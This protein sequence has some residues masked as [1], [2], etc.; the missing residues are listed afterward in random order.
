MVYIIRLCCNYCGKLGEKS[1][2]YLLGISGFAL[3]FLSD[4][5]D[6]KWARRELKF[7]FPLGA[8]LL[9][10]GTVLD[11]RFGNAV[12][13]GGLRWM[14]FVLAALL[15]ALEVYT[16]FFA[17]PVDA[18]Y[19]RPGE[20]RPACTTGV[21]ALCRHPGV[22]WFAGIYV[23]LWMAAGLPLWEAVLYSGLN[24]LLVAF[25]DRC[26]FPALLDGYDTYQ[27][28]TPFLIPNSK[29]IR[30]CRMKK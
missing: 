26:V 2:G 14:V 4:Y 7:C 20:K 6:W 3:F 23:C 28:A 5:N 30:D 29:S 24:V 11:L 22:L 16:L 17:L 19:T 9:V 12:V 8:V 18:S 27:T 21:Y 10:A 25:E 15:L 1:V 13:G